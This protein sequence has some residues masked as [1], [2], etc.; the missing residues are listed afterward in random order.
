MANLKKLLHRCQDVHAQ[1]YVHLLWWVW[2]ALNRCLGHQCRFAYAGVYATQASVDTSERLCE[3]ILRRVHVRSYM[4][5]LLM[6][7]GRQGWGD[8]LVLARYLSLVTRRGVTFHMR[9]TQILPVFSLFLLGS[10]RV[11]THTLQMRYSEVRTG[12]RTRHLKSPKNPDRLNL[13]I[14]VYMLGGGMRSWTPCFF[15]NIFFLPKNKSKKRDIENSNPTRSEDIDP[16]SRALHTIE[17]FNL[18][19]LGLVLLQ[20]RCHDSFLLSFWDILSFFLGW[21]EYTNQ[22]LDYAG[23]EQVVKPQLNH[24]TKEITGVCCFVLSD[25]YWGFVTIPRFLHERA[26]GYAPAIENRRRT[27]SSC[28][29]LSSPLLDNLGWPHLT[30]HGTGGLY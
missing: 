9:K 10:T 2:H 28:P 13:G 22:S 6:S 8:P 20:F 4:R 24:C 27:S 15:L 12:D 25:K 11:H 26:K 1:M 3:H 17:E 19:H 7:G 21:S 14:C 5:S 29:S 18:V 16:K 30:L 23:G